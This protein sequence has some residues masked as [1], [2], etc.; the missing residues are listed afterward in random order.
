MEF[1]AT[2]KRKDK[3]ELTVA[4]G[5]GSPKRS[6]LPAGFLLLDGGK[7]GLCSQIIEFMLYILLYLH[8]I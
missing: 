2:G 1:C 8:V 5:A 6:Y 7:C 3:T 4:P